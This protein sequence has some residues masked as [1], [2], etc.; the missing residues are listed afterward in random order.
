MMN[1][2]VAFVRS[3]F[4]MLTIVTT[5]LLVVQNSSSLSA[6]SILIGVLAGIAVAGALLSLEFLFKRTSIR[7]LNLVTLGLFFGYLLG[8]A[9]HLLIFTILEAAQIDGTHEVALI[10]TLCIYLSSCYTAL[11]LTFNAAEELYLSIPFIRLRPTAQKKR[12]LI[13]DCS[14]LA[15]SRLIDLANSGLLDSQLII[16]RFVLHELYL[17]SE[18]SDESLRHRARR[19]L[20]VVKKLESSPSLGL[21]YSDSDFSD[22]KESCAKLIRLARFLDSNILTADANRLDQSGAEELRIIDLHRLSKALK[23]ITHSGELLNVKVQRYGKEPRQGVGYLEDGTMVVVNGGAEHIGETIRAQVLSV[24]HTSSG[25]MIFCNAVLSGLEELDEEH[26][27][28]KRD[29]EA[30]LSLK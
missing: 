4:F 26:R 15:D 27:V 3:I 11:Q 23:P 22:I 25:R 29:P 9:I 19:A 10:T 1:F 16:P 8:S 14:A 28:A 7:L 17:Q 6:M 30:L 2:P 21:R 18:E 24:K 5:A 20:D 13:V 12:D